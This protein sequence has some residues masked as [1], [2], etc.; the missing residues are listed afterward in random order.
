MIN[1]AKSVLGTET[2]KGMGHI[3]KSGGYFTA[4]G[5]KIKALLTMSDEA[6]DHRTPATLYGIL[7][8]YREYIPDFAAKTEPLRELLGNDATPWGPHEY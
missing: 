6:M 1:L 3:W 7:S 5:K 4:T 2:A 8:F